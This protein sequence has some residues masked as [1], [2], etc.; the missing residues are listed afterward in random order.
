MSSTSRLPTQTRSGPEPPPAIGESSVV[1]VV[2]HLER[3]PRADLL[4]FQAQDGARLIARPSGTE[5]KLKLY[6]ELVARVRTRDEVEKARLALDA[7][8]ERIKS[9]VLARLQL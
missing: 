3:A 6:L 1:R 7:R 9:D 8:G 4:V 5:P 2:D